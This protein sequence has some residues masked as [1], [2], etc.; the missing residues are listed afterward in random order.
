MV[1]TL[2]HWLLWGRS[3]GP[4]VLGAFSLG[5]SLLI[6]VATSLRSSLITPYAVLGA[7]ADEER[8]RVMRSCVIAGWLAVAILAGLTLGGIMVVE[9]WVQPIGPYVVLTCL[10]VVAIPA[11][12]L[13]ELARHVSLADLQFQRT[14]WLDVAT[15][16]L[17][18]GAPPRRDRDRLPN[19]CRS[20]QRR[21]GEPAELLCDGS[22]GGRRSPA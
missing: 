18:L 17:Q 21:D 10:V 13:R 4:E 12:S 7:Q 9:R 2:F 3:A 8:R 20:P 11:W 19:I 14:L 1:R 5:F 15:S 22:L 16:A 6:L